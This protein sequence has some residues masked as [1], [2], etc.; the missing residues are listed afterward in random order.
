MDEA[1]V[2]F[3]PRPPKEAKSVLYDLAS[4]PP[5]CPCLS[6][7]VRRNG[8]WIRGGLAVIGRVNRAAIVCVSV[9]LLSP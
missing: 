7:L 2:D 3:R 9:H 8:L 5:T 6:I 1:A 4:V